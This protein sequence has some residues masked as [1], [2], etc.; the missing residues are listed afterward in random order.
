MK[1][2]VSESD[3][4]EWT[5]EMD[6]SRRDIRAMDPDL[7]RLEAEQVRKAMKKYNVHIHHVFVTAVETLSQDTPVLF[8]GALKG[9]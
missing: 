1:K 9:K 4:A 2:G 6:E 8:R 5:R 3:V 7:V